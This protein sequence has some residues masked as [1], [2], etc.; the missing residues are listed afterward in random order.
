MHVPVDEVTAI[1]AFEYLGSSEGAVQ[2]PTTTAGFGRVLLAA[3]VNRHSPTS[4][5]L[6][7]PL[8]EGIVS[9]SEH[10]ANRLGSQLSSGPRT[11]RFAFEDGNDDV[12]VSLCQEIGTLIVKVALDVLEPVLESFHGLPFPGFPSASAL[13]DVSLKLVHSGEHRVHTT[14]S[15]VSELVTVTVWRPRCQERSHTGVQSTAPHG[16]VLAGELFDRNVHGYGQYPP[17]QT[18]LGQSAIRGGRLDR[19]VKRDR[20]FGQHPRVDDDPVFRHLDTILRYREA[21][22]MFLGAKA[23]SKFMFRILFPDGK[24]CLVSLHEILD[25]ALSHMLGS[26]E[27]ETLVIGNVAFVHEPV[28]EP[29]PVFP[30]L[31]SR[32][33]V[34]QGGVIRQSTHSHPLSE[35][36]M[37]LLGRPEDHFSHS[38]CS[39]AVR[40]FGR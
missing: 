33:D 35:L 37:D 32:F 16:L 14:G 2:P 22:R 21:V 10:R 17:A 15:F 7:E 31:L 13:V 28:P 5:R 23:H 9:Q 25:H 4:A 39:A 29:V 30:V 26:I 6:Y 20:V 38:F 24:V 18:I 1:L 3:F 36:R 11:H 40:E 12:G 19:S 27:N 8:P 34:L